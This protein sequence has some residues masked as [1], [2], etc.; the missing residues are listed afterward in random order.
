MGNKIG[1]KNCATG[2]LSQ[3]KAINFV[4]MFRA[5]LILIIGGVSLLAYPRE[6]M[7][8]KGEWFYRL[9]G[10][11]S[12]IP[13][14]GE[15]TLPNTLD[16][17]HKSVYNPESDNT[18]QLRREFSF[19]GSANYGKN[20]KIPDNW[21]GKDILLF[22][23]RTKPSVVSVD[24]KR[25]G[26][27]SRISSPQY[28]DLTEFLTPGEHRL[29]IEV[30]N[31]DSLPPLVA[32]SS[33]AASESTQTNWNGILGD[34]YL[35][36]RN[37]Y[38]ISAI[39]ID[40]RNVPDKISVDVK[41]SKKLPR[42]YSLVV[43]K[44]RERIFTEK[45]YSG[46]D[47]MQI[48]LPIKDMELWSGRNPRLH[49]LAFK[50]L[51]PQGETIDVYELTTGFRNFDKSGNNFTINGNPVVL[52][53]TVNAAVFPVSTYSPVDA[54]SWFNYFSI[55]RDYGINH[56]RFHSWTPPDAAFQ[57][58]DMAGVYLLVELPIWGELDRDL[59][60]HNR[61]LKEDLKGIME[62]YAHHPSFV[63][64]S[65]GNELWGDISLMGE[66][67]QEAKI[68][69]P[70][71]L[72]TY[73]SNVYM[74]INGEIGG[75]DFII[76]S[77]TAD[78]ANNYIRGS[79][80]FTDSSDGGHF[81]SSYP[82]SS[83]NFGSAT[84]GITIPVVSHE[85]GQYQ[86]Y[87]DFSEIEK[88]K[89]NL[90]PD[91]LKVFKKL[92]EE[93]GLYPKM[94]KF[95]EASGRWAAKLYKA[96][97]ELAQRSPGIAGFEL[98][99]LQDYPA[100]GTAL[101]G[102]LNPFME[103]KGFISPKEWRQSSGDISVF[104]ELPKF[105]FY[106]GE[107]VKIPLVTINFSENPDAVSSIEWFTDFDSGQLET[108]PGLGVIRNNSIDM[109]MPALEVPQK[110]S[111]L[112][113]D[114]SG[115]V[116]NSYD[117]WVYPKK[118]P[119]VNNVLITTNLQKALAHL[120]QG[121]SVILCPDSATVSKA[122]LDPLFTPDFWNY[123]MYRSICD[124][125]NLK[126]S[127]GTLGLYINNEHPALKKFP[128]DNHTD[129]QWYPIV[130]NSRPLIIDRLPKDFDP[131]IE[132]IDNIERNFRLSLMLECR[133]GKGKLI[134]LS[135]NPDKIS[136]Y[137][138]GRW[139]LQSIKEYAGSK[140]FKPALTLTPEQV[141]NLVTKPSKSRLIKELKKENYS[142]RWE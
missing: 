13:G 37:P 129:W 86:S 91:N 118:M 30:N 50:I 28:Y 69:N 99:G 59:K 48:S 125:M 7:D 130:A 131:I 141:V 101:V 44:G 107:K 83:F 39:S 34:I 104:A 123:R 52:R 74:G 6:R 93:A 106:E 119:D 21:E 75:E 76:A 72:S 42:G 142:T 35:E 19:I 33:S 100:Q 9:T 3:K 8:L 140:E 89:G 136:E 117:F 16:N 132:V 112:L 61:F 121:D 98:F 135:T 18:S 105:T 14:E 97:M 122:S 58:A 81:N 47:A 25:V 64:F 45:I 12:S 127:P 103:S 60:F 92:S 108:D 67:M 88:Y 5:L 102:I 15:I 51:N 66:Y 134:I 87:P 22:I 63:M 113:S 62:S 56:V 54:D 17:A 94:L 116:S 65:T 46:V 114:A 49:D 71:L 77:T 11:P 138:E 111:L 36:G 90:K 23:E 80:S 137:P 57:A 84:Q 26:G 85:V 139:L 20:V 96:E 109:Q 24:G 68:L 70:R 31:S 110:K 38:N 133:V 126:A 124:E 115:N 32:R 1:N 55:L 73:G 53:G 41:F 79:L 27:N 82:N 40:D 95:H 2:S 29:E 78:A 10:A 4:M 120:K 128:T 43:E